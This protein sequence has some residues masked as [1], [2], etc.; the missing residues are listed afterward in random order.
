[1]PPKDSLGTVWCKRYQQL[2]SDFEHS[3]FK[4]KIKLFHQNYFLISSTVSDQNQTIVANT[5]SSKPYPRNLLVAFKFS[6]S[7][8]HI[9]N[10]RFRALFFRFTANQ[11]KIR[12]STLFTMLTTPWA[13]YIPKMTFLAFPHRKPF[14]KTSKN[15]FFR[16]IQPDC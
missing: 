13:C 14:I 9:Q 4:K 11:V 15:T 8:F 12:K 10:C 16:H 3:G 5:V 6:Y 1:M 7:H 2:W